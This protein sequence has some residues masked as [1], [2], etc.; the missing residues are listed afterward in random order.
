MA[1]RCFAIYLY[2][3]LATI[4]M[5]SSKGEE[6]EY[7]MHRLCL[8]FFFIFVICLLSKGLAFL[9]NGDLDWFHAYIKNMLG[10][11]EFEL[12]V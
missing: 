6:R 11:L 5:V 3:L 12:I 1:L 2:D 8:M 7:M 10:N 9:E 4:V